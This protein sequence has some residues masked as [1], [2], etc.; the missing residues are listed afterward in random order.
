MNGDRIVAFHQH[1]PAPLAD[2]DHKEVDLEVVWCLPLPKD[3]EDALLGVLVLHG[4]ALRTLEPADHVFHDS[5]RKEVEAAGQSAVWTAG[6]D[7]RIT[8]GPSA[9][10]AHKHT[11]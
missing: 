10:P 7:W 5:P 8:C 6:S 9:G 2:A 11:S 1:V 4:G 3:F